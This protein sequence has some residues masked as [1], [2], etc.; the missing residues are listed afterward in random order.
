MNKTDMYFW[1]G[2]I[3]EPDE[4]FVKVVDKETFLEYIKNE[5][6]RIAA[7]RGLSDDDE[8]GEEEPC[9]GCTCGG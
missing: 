6:E 4:K 9:D 3:G 8:D 1:L 7:T 2:D 5:E